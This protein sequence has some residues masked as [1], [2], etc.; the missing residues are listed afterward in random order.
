MKVSAGPDGQ[1]EENAEKEKDERDDK[2]C[3]MHEKRPPPPTP[4]VH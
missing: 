2:E 1:A 3:N 4:Q